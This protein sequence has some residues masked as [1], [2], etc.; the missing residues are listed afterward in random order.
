MKS[1]LLVSKGLLCLYD[2][3]NNTW[4]LVDMEFLFSCLTRYLTRELSS[5]TL[6]EKFYIYARP[7]IILY[8]SVIK[9][10]VKDQLNQENRFNTYLLLRIYY[11]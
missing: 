8:M 4:L 11:L 10:E 2:K 9:L 5:W 6:E 7:C 1:V 3:Q